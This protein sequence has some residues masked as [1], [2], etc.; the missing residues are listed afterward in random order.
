MPSVFFPAQPQ[1]IW[2]QGIPSQAPLGLN[3]GYPAAAHASDK[4]DPRDSAGG[5]ATP[6]VQKPPP[7][8][9]SVPLSGADNG[10][11]SSS[12]EPALPKPPKD[13][14][15][16]LLDALSDQNVRYYAGPHLYE[17]LRKL[18]ALTQLLPGSGTVQSTRDASQAREEA[19]AGNYGKAATHFGMGT[20]NAALD[21]LPPAKLAILGGM[22]ARTFPWERL[23]TALEMEAAGKSAKKIWQ[24]AG[25]ERGAADNWKFEISDK[26]YRIR[27]RAGEPSMWEGVT[28][29][30][31]Y[32]HHAHPGMREAYPD[33]AD[34][35]SFLRVR[36]RERRYGEFQPDY[37]TLIVQAPDLAGARNV[38]IHELQHLIDWLEKHPPGG[39]PRYFRDRGFSAQ[40]AS[41]RY[42]KLIGEVVARNAERR[43]RMPERLRRIRPPSATESVP[44]HQQINLYDD[45]WRE[46][47]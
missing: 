23:P 17:A 30:P 39:S 43:L 35:Q 12:P 41:D 21:W 25:L 34:T 2:T 28:H 24:E 7:I 45:R 5:V 14:R 29:A 40:E 20:V 22:M 16:W 36:P 27:P 42:W 4:P 3:S 38:G 9:P 46:D 33:L 18:H 19:Q 6:N 47:R 11:P 1:N 32:E 15:T 10:L 26:G 8:R 13:F 44:R 31:L 37:E